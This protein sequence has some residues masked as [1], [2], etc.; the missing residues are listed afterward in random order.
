[1]ELLIFLSGRRWHTRGSVLRI[2]LLMTCLQMFGTMGLGKEEG[3][4]M[5][6]PM[7][8]CVPYYLGSTSS[9]QAIY[10]VGTYGLG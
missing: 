3:E 4:K 9:T 10:L 7:T 5:F 2:I 8:G 6:M 1:M